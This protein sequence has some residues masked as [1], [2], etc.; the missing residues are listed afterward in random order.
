MGADTCIE[1]KTH[2]VNYYLLIF[3]NNILSSG[4]T[5][6]HYALKKKHDS[7]VKYLLKKGI[8]F[9]NKDSPALLRIFGTLNYDEILQIV[10]SKYDYLFFFS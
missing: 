4:T 9:S 7:I 2:V 10:N 8:K 1:N 6:L 3:V 5:P